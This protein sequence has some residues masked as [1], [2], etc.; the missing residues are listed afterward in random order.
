MAS[1]HLAEEM[2]FVEQI[3][4]VWFSGHNQVWL[5]GDDQSSEGNWRWLDGTSMNYKKWISGEPNGGRGENCIENV[6]GRGWN[7][8]A[9]GATR[10]YVCKKCVK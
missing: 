1:I 2:A 8:L 7:D 10:G 9:C 4:R 6:L 5:G 3:I